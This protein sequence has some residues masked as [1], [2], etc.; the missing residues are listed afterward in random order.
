MFEY[1]DRG[2]EDENGLTG[3]RKRLD[4]IKLNQFV[5]ND[6]SKPDTSVT[7]FGTTLP[8]PIVIAPTAAAGLMWYDGEVQLARAAGEA[9]VP[10]CVA[11]Q[12]MTSMEE[13]AER[14]AKTKLWFQLYIFEDRNLTYSL[15]KRA[16]SLGIDTL[17]LTVDTARNPPKKEWNTRNGY[18]IPIT[19]SLAGA[20]DLLR[21][22]GWT[23]SVL[24][25][26]LATTGVP[27]YRH[28]PDEYRTKITRASVADN[29]KL[30]RK[31]TWED[32]SDIRRRWQGNL[33]VKGILTAADAERAHRL[34]ADGVVVSS[35]GGRNFDSAP[36]AIDVV[37]QIA[38]ALG[39]R[40][41]I[42]ADSGIRRGSDVVKYLAAGAK[43]VLIGRATLYGTAVA[44]ERGAIGV[45]EI[46]LEELDH[47]LAF[48]GQS[49][50]ANLSRDLLWNVASRTAPQ[51]GP[52]DF[53][54]S[55]IK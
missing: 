13:I 10:F 28:Y 31:L 46:L 43:A 6:I 19:P 11:T 22:P 7:L 16:D 48:S 26:Y 42:L 45:L 44:G 8:A 52:A 27:T 30:A 25:R 33:I 23:A 47:C 32:V 14:A 41:T 37:P 5:L 4:A 55:R 1:I 18:G 9:G 40:M 51:E 3:L 12:S 50:V 53:K 39:Q 21:H 29:V 15:L 24:L 38:D 2:T 34:G 20:L 49:S 36:A 17:L 35:H 54:P